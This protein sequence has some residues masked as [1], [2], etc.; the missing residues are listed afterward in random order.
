MMPN[1][2]RVVTLSAELYRQTMQYATRHEI[3]WNDAI[4]LLVE[5]ALGE[6]GGEDS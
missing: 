4:R 5:Q 3:S 6:D 1:V 2:N